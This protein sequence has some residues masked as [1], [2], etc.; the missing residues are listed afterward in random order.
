MKRPMMRLAVPLALF[1]VWT[2][3]SVAAAVADNIFLSAGG[4]VTLLSEEGCGFRPLLYGNGGRLWGTTVGPEADPESCSSE[5]TFMLGGRKPVPWASGVLSLKP[6]GSSVVLSMSCKVIGGDISQGGAGVALSLPV[7]VFSNRTWQV[8]GGERQGFPQNPT[9][10]GFV[11][12]RRL[13]SFTVDIPDGALRLDFP[14][15][16]FFSWRDAGAENKAYV[17][18]FSPMGQGSIAKDSSVSFS[19][20]ISR[21]DGKALKPSAVERFVAKP[22]KDWIP[23]SYRKMPEKGSAL[24]FSQM[25]Q[26]DAPAGKYG[27]LKAAGGHFEFEGKPGKPVRFWGANITSSACF[28]KT[29]AD[30]VELAERLARIGYNSVRIHHHDFGCSYRTGDPGKLN[31]G[32]MDRLDRFLAECIKRGLYI[33]TD[34]YVSRDVKWRDIGVD[35]PGNVPYNRFKGEILYREAAYSNYCAFAQAFLTHVNRYTGRRYADEPALNL[36]SL[37][38]EGLFFSGWMSL[39]K[40]PLFREVWKEWFEGCRRKDPACFPEFSADAP[41]QGIYRQKETEGARSDVLT[42]FSVDMERRFY[43]RMT[44]FLRGIGVKALLTDVNFG[45]SRP[46]MKEMRRDFDYVDTHFYYEHPKK[47]GG[48]IFIPN[49]HPLARRDGKELTFDAKR[50]PDRPYTQSEYNWSGPCAWRGTGALIGAS[51]AAILD[52]SGVWR[53]AYAQHSRVIPEGKG[54]PGAFDVAADPV[55]YAAERAAVALYLRGDMPSMPYR[56]RCRISELDSDFFRTDA[57]SK[58]VAVD[59]ERTAGGCALVGG[60]IN[61]AA[62]DFILEGS[63]ACVWVTALDGM[64]IVRSKRLLLAHATDVLGDGSTFRDSTRR[65]LIA[66]G[67]SPLVQAGTADVTIRFADPAKYAVYRLDTAGRR[68]GRVSSRAS[69][70]GLSFRADVAADPEF[71]TIFYEIARE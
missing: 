56:G 18:R 24:D 37:V 30:A 17:F 38:N 42:A 50:F 33:T 13:K 66:W 32:Y 51:A 41:P 21:T 29:E 15:R 39:C 6:E 63:P 3:L 35:R 45:P 64:A 71:A 36:I 40:E 48:W 69:D 54:S 19:L 22:G 9:G 59:T 2:Q 20:R 68:L 5:F 23:C 55:N 16:T 27:F 10:T 12:A 34:L 28:P 58:T 14:E 57:D 26:L 46:G 62:M 67:G 25:G 52:W 65:H 4:H 70:G 47:H 7:G 11:R 49:M 1:L 43:R 31:A 60:R 53:F 8:D 61:T 44:A